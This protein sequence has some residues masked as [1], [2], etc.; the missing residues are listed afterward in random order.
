MADKSLPKESLPRRPDAQP[1]VAPEAPVA[2]LERRA[3]LRRAALIGVPVLIASVPS[4]AVWAQPSR[5]AGGGPGGGL[6]KGHGGETELDQTAGCL[7]S[8]IGSSE[9][10]RV[11]VL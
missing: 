2:E 7:A 8:H 1:E 9:C 4:R 3:F 5:P 6:K 11:S 10:N